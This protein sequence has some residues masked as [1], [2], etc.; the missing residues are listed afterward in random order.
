MARRGE[1]HSS[2]NPVTGTGMPGWNETTAERMDRS[3]AVGP[4]NTALLGDAT[5][6]R[7]TGRSLGKAREAVGPAYAETGASALIY[8]GPVRPG[9]CIEPGASL[10]R[11]LYK[12][13]RGARGDAEELGE[14]GA[15]LLIEGGTD[16]PESAGDVALRFETMTRAAQRT[17]LDGRGGGGGAPAAAAV[18]DASS[19]AAVK[20]AARALEDGRMTM[21]AF[22]AAAAAALGLAGGHELPA[23]ADRLLR[24][25]ARTGRVDV[26]RI[27]STLFGSASSSSAATAAAEPPPAHVS[28]AHA[29]TVQQLPSGV[30]ERDVHERPTVESVHA[31]QAALARAGASGAA[32]G[33]VSR[34]AL[35]I[36]PGGAVTAGGGPLRP[37][38]A[39]AATAE[40]AS[41]TRSHAIGGKY[42]A[43]HVD[44][45]QAHHGD[46]LGWTTAPTADGEEQEQQS[47]RR[48]PP[49]RRLYDGPSHAVDILSVEQRAILTQFADHNAS[50]SMPDDLRFRDL[51]ARPHRVPERRY[52][53]SGDIIAG[54]PANAAD[55]AAAASASLDMIGGRGKSRVRSAIADHDRGGLD[56]P[57]AYRRI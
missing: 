24:E 57:Y 25:S 31:K 18:G 46:I 29:A 54:R 52:A 30:G 42:Y 9:V 22:R 5:L 27:I 38:P 41:F 44:P 2:F 14:T 10:D 33:T 26:E 36:G 51:T 56:E 40:A 11:H 23:A 12:M 16:E 39:Y 20:T 50:E 49:D 48:A 19:R 4:F 34:E 45:A 21:P 6:L 32:P 8:G 13:G 35:F 47:R 1:V 28:A 43:P 55:A 15:G 53:T 37:G 17:G 7:G 3:A